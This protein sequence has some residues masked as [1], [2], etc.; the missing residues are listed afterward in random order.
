MPTRNPV[1][2][3]PP[4]PEPYFPPFAV[5]LHSSSMRNSFLPGLALIGLVAGLGCR[6]AQPTPA[7]VNPGA[8]PATPD[9]PRPNA[10]GEL[11]GVAGI[12]GDSG[13]APTGGRGGGGGANAA[14]R[15]YNRVITAQAKTK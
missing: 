11:P 8:R 2:T 5:H 13:A 9:N 7:P 12:G 6:P 14:P 3:R 4:V 10:P 15:P 1:D